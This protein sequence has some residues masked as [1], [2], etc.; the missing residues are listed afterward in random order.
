MFSQQEFT[1]EQIREFV[2]QDSVRRLNSIDELK[3]EGTFFDMIRSGYGQSIWDKKINWYP[4]IDLEAARRV[5]RKDFFIN[6]SLWIGGVIV[7][8][9][10]YLLYKRTKKRNRNKKG[11]LSDREVLFY[12]RKSYHSDNTE[13]T[14]SDQGNC[15]P[16]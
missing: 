6:T 14:D 7:I 5:V 11:K 13:S 12:V 1:K 3:Y 2:K 4:E 15:Q 8:A 9:L 10:L 16:S